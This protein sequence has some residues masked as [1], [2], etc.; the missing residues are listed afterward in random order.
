MQYA[1]PAI[2]FAD[3]ADLLISRG[4]IANRDELIRR[5][6]AVN[7]YRLSGYLYP[8][9]QRIT[10]PNAAGK[11][12]ITVIDQF[13]TG[14]TLTEVWDRYRFDRQLRLLLMDAIERIEVSVRTRMVYEFT[15]QHGAFGHL[16]HEHLPKLK[17]EEY[18]S[19]RAKLVG[20]AKKSKEEFVEHFFKKYQPE[21]QELPLWI[22]CEL[23]DFGGMQSFYRGMSDPL[24]QTVAKSFGLS[25]ELMDSWLRALNTVRKRLRAS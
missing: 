15:L 19:W 4:L 7:Y 16:S 11:P 14:T 8:F 6:E 17:V 25:D 24:R 2:S 5:L 21:H 9:R 10:T 20:N 22:L 1:K 23:M 12:T 18:L 3:Q 13:K